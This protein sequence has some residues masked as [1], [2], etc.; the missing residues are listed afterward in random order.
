M[1]WYGRI[2]TSQR[3]S[4]LRNHLHE[5]GRYT[6]YRS[7]TPADIPPPPIQIYFS[8]LVSS[9][10]TFQPKFSHACYTYRSF[11]HSWFSHLT[12]LSE[13]C[14][15][16]TSW[17]VP[18]VRGKK[19]VVPP[20]YENGLAQSRSGQSVGKKTLQESNTGY[21]ARIMRTVCKVRGLTLLLRAGTL[22][23]CGD[24][25]FF[26]VPPLASDA[27][28]TKLHPFLEDVLQTVDNFE[29][30]GLGVPFS[31]LE[32]V[33]NRMGERCE[34]NSVFGLEKVDRCNPIR[35]STLQSRYRPMRFLGFSNQEKGAPRQEISKWS[36]VC[37][38]FSR[39]RWSV[40]RSASLAKGG[41]S[42][43]RPSPHLHKVPTRSNK[44][45]PRALQ[46]AVAIRNS[47]R[48]C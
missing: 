5:E 2:P 46:K 36:P 40:V 27:L 10:E 7:K 25:L 21:S 44:V 29:I 4:H 33:R 3:D 47:T 11:H 23:R 39:C 45:S 38:T 15:L 35:P 41:T 12:I 17:L 31:R 32:K 16:C 8:Q 14:K 18:I 28:L 48:K 43:K 24:G 1:Q 6:A 9:H 42:K 22:W 30:S 34:L 20:E 13:Q 26:E 37:S 19:A